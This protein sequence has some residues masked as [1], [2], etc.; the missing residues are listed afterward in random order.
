[1]EFLRRFVPHVLPKG[2][3]KIRHYGLLANAQRQARL[4]LCR[5]LLLLASVAL[6]LPRADPVL[7]E[8]AQPRCCP[9]GGS[10]RLTYRE[11]PPG[12]ATPPSTAVPLNSS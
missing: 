11:R 3:V 6:S 4:A 10:S 1:V 2:F 12:Q 8:P 7:M 5:S 9:H